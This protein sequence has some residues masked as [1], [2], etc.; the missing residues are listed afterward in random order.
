[1]PQKER[2]LSPSKRDPRATLSRPNK[3]RLVR[4]EAPKQAGLLVLLVGPEGRGKDMLINA[5]RR[6]FAADASMAFPLRVMTRP[7]GPNEEHVAVNRR[8]FRDMSSSGGFLAAWELGGHNVAL[9]RS[10]VTSLAAGR[11][12]VVAASDAAVA[13]AREAGIEVRVVEVTSGPDAASL[14]IRG[15]V[16]E[17]PEVGS[18]ALSDRHVIHHSGDLAEAVRRFHALL[19]ALRIEQLHDERPSAGR[20][21]KRPEVLRRMAAS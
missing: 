18:A 13:Q 16:A 19:H 6:R 5:A 7:A 1:M 10:V 15:G 4:V 11:M 3:R 2:P 17:R 21:R 12:V 8:T 9:P 14:R 20:F